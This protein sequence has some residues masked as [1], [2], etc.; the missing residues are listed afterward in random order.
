VVSVEQCAALGTVG[1]ILLADLSHY[2]VLDGGVRPAIS[3]HYDFLHDQSI[4]R[5]VMRVD[6]Q[7]EFMTP[8]TPFSGGNTQSP[9]VSLATRA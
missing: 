4:F 9:F 7:P 6:G 3:M 1:D 8:V 5:F 2:R